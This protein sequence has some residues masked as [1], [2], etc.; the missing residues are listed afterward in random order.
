MKSDLPTLMESSNLD[1]LLIFGD[2]LHNPPM[3]YFTGVHHVTGALLVVKRGEAP[4]LFCH[5]MERDE[6]KSTGLATRSLTDYNLRAILEETKGDHALAN[7][8]LFQRMLTDA[9]LTKGRVAIYGQQDMGHSY[10]LLVALSEM[11]SELEFVGELGN[12][13]LLEARATK[14]STEVERIRAVQKHTTEIVGQ[15]A[16]YLSSQRAKDGVLVD[17]DGQ[18]I[19]VAQVKSNINLWIA[20]RGLDNPD[21]TIFAP[22]AEGG[23]PH[24]MGSPDALLRLGE[25]IVFDIFP[26]EAGGGYWSDFTRT[27]CLGHASDEAQ[28]LYDDVRFV[29]DT[30]MSEIHV[31]ERCA[32]FQH[33]TCELFEQRGHPTV[34]QDAT[35]KAGY[36]HSLAHGLG[37]DVHESPGFYGDPKTAKD[38]LRR[39]HVITIEPGLYYPERGLGMRL[40]D[41]VYMR[42][43]TG[44]PDILAPY[45]LDLVIPLKK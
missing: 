7:G 29:Y 10:G 37:L 41:A 31:D 30:I 17:K 15:V 35:I 4:L 13:V 42:P 39:G 26:K 18:P 8:R 11:M 43:D 9:D 34:R 14:D 16:D 2:A 28:A 44:K 45:P 24:S 1:A 40:E 6:A 3:V 27:W 19:T 12:S 25:P 5:N 20:E 33:R 36:V 23:V 38:F 32:V 21:G 22:G